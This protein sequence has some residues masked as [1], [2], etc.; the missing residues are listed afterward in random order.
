MS[1]SFYEHLLEELGDRRIRVTYDRGDLEL[2]A[3]AYRH[4]NS[5]RV[6][7][8]LIDVV[9]EEI[10]LPVKGA[11]STTFRRQDVR[12]GLEPDDCFWI[13]NIAAILGRDDIDLARDPPPDLAI[14][15]D[16]TSSSIDRLGIYAALRVPEVWRFD[17]LK[18]RV[19]RLNENGEYDV[20]DY[21][22]TFPFLPLEKLVEFIE[23]SVEVDDVTLRREFRAWLRAEVLPKLSQQQDSETN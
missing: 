23:R 9:A 17:G 10:E 20:L 11:R 6:I 2:M 7:G 4:E 22:P 16:V 8:W 13:E 18:I 5:G 21:S 12:R 14:E 15:V 3:P 19:Y 1:W